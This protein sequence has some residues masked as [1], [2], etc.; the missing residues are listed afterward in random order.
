MESNISTVSRKRKSSVQDIRVP[1]LNPKAVVRK[2]RYKKL[3]SAAS[4]IFE[5]ALTAV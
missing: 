1:K 3:L 4:C 2:P 5:K